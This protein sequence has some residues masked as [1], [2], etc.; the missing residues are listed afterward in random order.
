MVYSRSWL[1]IYLVNSTGKFLFNQARA[2]SC[3]GCRQKFVCLFLTFILMISYFT[4]IPSLKYH[5]SS[6]SSVL[7]AYNHEDFIHTR[8]Q[9]RS[10][11]LFYNLYFFTKH[12]LLPQEQAYGSL[13]TRS[14]AQFLVF[15][16][17]S[18]T[19]NFQSFFSVGSH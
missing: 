10:S 8:T 15:H 13:A 12:I 11:H 14:C 16:D 7:S 5:N 2:N 6:L 4:H 18:M 9:M 3:S 17:N 1:V 19:E